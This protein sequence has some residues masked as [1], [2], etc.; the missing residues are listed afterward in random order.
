MERSAF[1]LFIPDA[2]LSCAHHKLPHAVTFT[3]VYLQKIHT[4]GEAAHVEISSNIMQRV[5]EEDVGAEV[6]DVD[7]ALEAVDGGW[8]AD[9]QD[10][11]GRIWKQGDLMTDVIFGCAYVAGIGGLPALT[12]NSLVGSKHHEHLSGC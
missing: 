5:A 8:D 6:E 7:V 3:G 12:A 11:C 4:G 2:G 9:M 1:K 10:V